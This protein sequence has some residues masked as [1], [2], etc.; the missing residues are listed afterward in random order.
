MLTQGGGLL[1]IVEWVTLG[2]V[3]G[4]LVAA[5]RTAEKGRAADSAHVAAARAARNNAARSSPA[6]AARRAGTGQIVE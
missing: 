2:F 6:L 1:A 3:A 5:Y 4:V